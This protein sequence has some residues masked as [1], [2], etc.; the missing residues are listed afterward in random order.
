[1]KTTILLMAVFFTLNSLAETFNC[2]VHKNYSFSQNLIQ[3]TFSEND[4][5]EDSEEYE[6]TLQDGINAHV[7]YYPYQDGLFLSL[8][9]ER[10]GVSAQANFDEESD[11]YTSVTLRKGDNRYTLS[12]LKNE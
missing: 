11:I 8:T 6:I 2:T 3:T 5:E 4:P 7:G 9:D 1:M 12:C 10:S